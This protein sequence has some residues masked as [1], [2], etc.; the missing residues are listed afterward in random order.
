MTGMSRREPVQPAERT[1]DDP[2]F[3]H[4]A[5]GVGFVARV[6]ARPD[7]ALLRH[8]LEA[9]GRLAHRGAVAADGRSGDGAGV[10][11]ALPRALLLSEAGRCG[12]A[13]DEADLFG[14]GMT[15]LPRD[16]ERGR[17]QLEAALAAEGLQAVGWR[18]VPTDGDALGD[19][20][21]DTAP[22]IWQVIVRGPS[23][24]SEPQLERH[25]YVARKRFERNGG[26]GYICSLSCRMIV[27]KAL[28]SGGQLPHFYTDLR[29]PLYATSFALFHQRYSTN[30]LPSWRLAQPLRLV[31]H[32]GEINTFW[33]NRAW[34]RARACDLPTDVRPVLTEDASD[35]ANLD[36]VAELLTLNGRSLDHAMAMLIVP[37][38]EEMGQRLSPELRAFYRYRGPLIEPW[39]GPAALT[40]ADGRVV[41]AVLDRNGLRPCRFL[42]TADGLVVAGSEVGLL[43]LDDDA[44]IEKGRL[45]P[46]EMLLVDLVEQRVLHDGEAKQ[47]LATLA[48]FEAWAGAR[49][50]ALVTGQGATLTGHREA[51]APELAERD[52]AEL[53]SLHRLFGFTAEDVKFVIAPM[54]A[55]GKE[56][57]WSMGDDTPIPPLARSPRSL[58][59]FLRQRFA[60]VTNPPIDPLREA[61]MMSLRTW[62]GPRPHLLRDGP[63]PVSVEL[64]SPL[65]RSEDV[66]ALEADR[67]LAVAVIDCGYAPEAGGLPHAIDEICRRAEAA[68]RE[69]AGLLMLSDRR[70]DADL[71]PVPMVLA[72]G[73]VHQHLVS[74]GIRTRAGLGVEAGDCWDVH[75]VAV[76]TG[77]GAAAICPWL[78]LATARRF[79]PV[80]G[81]SS[82]LR[83]LDAGLRKVM[84]KMGISTVASYRGAQLFEVLGLSDAIVERCFAGTP[85]R[86]GGL[87]WTH[88][89]AMLLRRH[90]ATAAA[91]QTAQLPDF[92]RIRFRRG[93]SAEHHAWRPMAVRALQRAVGSLRR[94]DGHGDGE[95]WEEFRQLSQPEGAVHLRDLLDVLPAGPACGVEEVEPAG[96]IVP[97]F[98]TSAMSLG[99]LSPEAHRTLAIAMNRLGARSNTG[100][101]GEDPALYAPR[102]D[103]E[104]HDNKI[105]QIAS[106]RFGVTAE[107]VARAEELEI[108]IAQ[109][110]KPGEGGQLPGHKVTEMIA[111]LRHAQPGISLISP[112]PHHDIYSIE[113]LAQLIYDLKRCNPTARVGVK[114]VAEAGVGTIAAGVA[115]AYA[116]YIVVSGHAGGTGASA[117]SSIKHAGSPWELG[118]PE[119]Q[120]VLTRNGLRSRVRLRVDGG[121]MTAFDVLLAALLGAE[122]YGFGTAPLVAMGCDM[123]R[124]CHLNSCPT[125][126]ATQRPELRAK[127][128]GTPEQVVRFF[129]LLAENVRRLLAQ[130][131]L[132]SLDEAIGRADLLRQVRWDG[133]LDLTP[134]LA[135]VPGD[136]RR[137][138]VPRN[139]RPETDALDDVMWSAAAAAVDHGVPFRGAWAI[140]NRDRS[141]GARISGHI[142]LRWGGDGLPPSTIRLS[143][144][145]SAGQSFGV[146][147]AR[148]LRLELDGEAND[149]VGKGLC[150]AEL[151]LRPVGHARKAPHRNVILGNVALYGAT[152]GSLHAAGVAGE[153]FAVRNSGATAVVEG[154]G[155]HGC[156]YMT[157]GCVLVLGRTGSGFGAG[158]TGGIAFV[159]DEDGDLSTKLN[160]DSVHCRE[161]ESTERERVRQLVQE[162]VQRTGSTHA[163]WLLR[164]SESVW[165]RFRTVVPAS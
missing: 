165:Q 29:D 61:A 127:F 56:A 39:D 120:Q 138:L 23:G 145:G 58:Y 126:I 44:V 40:F 70:A 31:A 64:A 30:T 124:Q 66:A 41:G 38:W 71:A 103:G 92:G 129:T 12:W 62:L 147:G 72:L 132:R 15:F 151:I 122:E 13:L 63:Q 95:G 130:L 48:P 6:D 110:S 156:E 161:L 84:S 87:D 14:V 5:C 45:G 27:Y 26:D 134:M 109:G 10:L 75:H 69:G 131:G 67:D 36:E 57:T 163:A 148:G 159:F 2:R 68:V 80:Q 32:N 53:G 160:R 100:E 133:G 99:A 47:R 142:A 94:S 21:R 73:A 164:Q 51:T 112:P 152:G 150:G 141:V 35:S 19:A 83:A 140:R 77:F 11:T 90:A 102:L 20:A 89:E 86:I 117:L 162:H 28:S 144:R 139:D 54:A 18:E 123:A 7:P 96:S 107:Y 137:C 85:S 76:L 50:L 16:P 146:F 17:A 59:A 82:L 79:D 143:V 101:G 118:V 78:A 128:R 88:I 97:R 9:V 43:D 42:I 155:D 105:K 65:V 49:P 3:E 22:A 136:A 153:R 52:P 24:I 93:E 98:V 60:Q 37:A 74:S 108:K 91:L 121:L 125:G 115:K 113:D 116:D 1:L 114:L 119:V 104:R 4:D 34:V 135:S 158:M 157:G 111:R 33:G 154:V 81:E 8:A 149:Y 46:G 25:L 106:G 55:E